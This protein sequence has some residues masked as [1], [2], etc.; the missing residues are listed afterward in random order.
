MSDLLDIAVAAHGGSKRWQKLERIKADVSV[1]GGLLQAKGRGDA[2]TDARL[3][4]DPHRQHVERSPFGAPGR[5][6]VYE[7]ERTLVLTDAGEV[8]EQR[9]APREAFAGHGY[10]T[11][12]DDHHLIYFSGYAMWTYLTTPFLFKLAGF[13]A[14]EI[15]PWQEDGETWRRLKVFF[16]A[17]VHSHSTEQTV[18]FDASGILRRHDY[19]VDLVGGTKSA[20]YAFNPKSFGG[21][22][23]PTERRIYVTGP[24]NKPLPGRVVLSI[25]LHDIEPG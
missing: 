23:Y 3:T 2:L 7:P 1:S 18:Y 19:S 16:P 25:Q 24:D 8:V 15:E 4:L 9:E 20:N 21:I 10:G 5:R 13:R 22:V 11:P 6:S 17:Q 12:W 14:E